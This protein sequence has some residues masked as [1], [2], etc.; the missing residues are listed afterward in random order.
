[1]PNPAGRPLYRYTLGKGAIW[2]SPEP[3]ESMTG[4]DVFVRDPRATADARQNLYLALLPR[5]GAR[6]AARVEAKAGVWRAMVTPA[7][8]NRLA[9]LFPRGPLSGVTPATLAVGGRRLQWE[10]HPQWPCAALL[11]ARGR[12]LAATGGRALRVDGAEAAR[13]DSA[14]L[15]VALDGKPLAQAG[16]LAAA[17]TGGGRLRWRSAARDMAAWVV[18]WRDGRAVAVA[19]ATARRAAG[20]WE[21][22]GPPNDLV[23]V[24]PKAQRARWLRALGRR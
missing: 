8:P 17:L 6:P 14:W 18:E 12:P 5:M 13:G 24:C 2:Y 10:V 23:L 15:L 20:G 11:D 3:W 19:P 4:R 16:A 1:V 22:S 7:G 9:A 21:V